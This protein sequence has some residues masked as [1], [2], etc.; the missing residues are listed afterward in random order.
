MCRSCVLGNGSGYSVRHFCAQH[1]SI[2]SVGLLEK[3]CLFA[4]RCYG[5][6]DYDILR[7]PGS[8]RCLQ[9]INKCE[10]RSAVTGFD[11]VTQEYKF[12]FVFCVFDDG[13]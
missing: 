12:V 1:V 8:V 4:H 3:S 13:C 2:I 10:Q 6:S 9:F 11:R 5:E 7:M